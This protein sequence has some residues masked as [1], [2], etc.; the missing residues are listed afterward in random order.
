MVT[1]AGMLD[2]SAA[3]Q[4]YQMVE[5][6]G[7]MRRFSS[8]LDFLNAGLFTV[9]SFSRLLEFVIDH[10]LQEQLTLKDDYRLLAPIRRPPAIYCL[11]RNF[12][13][14]ARET[15]ADVPKEPIVFSK[16]VTS[17]VGPED[18]VVYKK[19]LTRVDP[20]AE[21]AVIIGKR[22]ANIAEDEA[23]E[24][25]AGYTAINDVTE[26]DLQKIDM[27]AGHPWLRSKGID[28]FC[29]MG[30]WVVLP[31][32]IRMPVELDIE[33]RVNGQVRQKDNTRALTFKIPFLIHWI[34]RYHTLYP[35]DVISTG[36][37]EGIKPVAPGDVMEVY[38]EKIG[39]LRNPVVAEQ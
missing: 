10:K 20:E 26:R 25:I 16:A 18:P 1:D 23:E 39:I 8:I 21:L 6:G 2:M 31:D 32:E 5:E 13:A 15:G 36:T 14:H 27:A 9:Q 30:P 37:P 3:L 22:G 17:V 28:T 33:M 34:S 24:F 19:W 7:Q 4:V 11:G 38:V 29:P 35:G 12:P